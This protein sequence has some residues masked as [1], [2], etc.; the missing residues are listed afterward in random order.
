MKPIVL[1][2]VIFLLALNTYAGGITPPISQ[3]LQNSIEY[4]EYAKES[5][6][7]GTVLVQVIVDEN[8]KIQ[9]VECNSDN[10]SLKKY[11]IGK[12]C[13][14]ELPFTGQNNN[15]EIN[16]KFVFKLF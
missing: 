5:H 11:V 6:E 3:L 9:I 8:G 2:S 14:L 7:E 1:L 10:E 15:E 12:L 16:L 13:S 4:P